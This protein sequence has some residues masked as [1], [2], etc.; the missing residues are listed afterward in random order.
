MGTQT[1]EPA[2]FEGTARSANPE[3]RLSVW[4]HVRRYA[5]PLPMI[6]TAT[7]RRHAGDWAGACA[8]AGFDVD[9][10]PRSLAR[11]HGREL[12]AR[13]RL[14]LRRLAPDLL[15]W[16]MPRTSPDGLLR[17]G[18]TLALARYPTAE[19]ALHLVARTPPA[20][21]AGRQRVQLALHDGTRDLTRTPAPSWGTHP[22]ARPDR[23]FRLDLHRHVWDAERAHE[24]RERSGV[25]R[26]WDPRAH[27]APDSPDDWAAVPRWADEAARLLHAEGSPDGGA[28]AVRLGRGRRL[29]LEIHTPP[30]APPRI[31][32]RYAEGAYRC[33]TPAGEGGCRAGCGGCL[34]PATAHG[35]P[36]ALPV[37]PDAATWIP[38]DLALLTAGLIAPEELHPL[39]A[40]ALAPGRARAAGPPGG[41]PGAAGPRYV[42]CRGARHR[43]GLVGGVLTALDHDG[44]EVRREALLAE[45]NGPPLPCFQAI[46]LAHRHPESLPDVRARLAHGDVRGALA[47]VEALLGPAARLGEGG[48]RDALEAAARGRIDHGLYRSGL[49]TPGPAPGRRAFAPFTR[50]E[51]RRRTDFTSHPRHAATH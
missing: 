2:A 40:A 10:T 27:P 48:L 38:P 25:T 7:A 35:E 46:A 15:R 8:A 39:V 12:A 37:L 1:F 11:T 29:V 42:D 23:R 44:E 9:F 21:A 20:R 51:R 30:G 26:G 49:A 24:L 6:D 34:G 22:H 5:V 28:V 36:R 50:E 31:A 13:V 41:P 43:I 32:A 16:H 17:P 19:G 3:T 18:V 33:D 4:L 47:E 14:D 45:L